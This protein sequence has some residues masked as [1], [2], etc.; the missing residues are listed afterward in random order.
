VLVAAEKIGNAKDPAVLSM[1]VTV[2]VAVQAAAPP[3]V[4]QRQWLLW[5]AAFFTLA[6]LVHNGDH[7]R[8]GADAVTWE[9]FVL[10]T[11]AIPIE[12][13]VV[14]L[15]FGRHR[16][17]PLVA[18]VAGAVL[19]VGYV[20]VHFLPSWSDLSDSFVSARNAS[21]LSWGAASLE[22]AAALI[23][24]FVGLV[25]LTRSGWQVRSPATDADGDARPLGAALLHPV[26]LAMIVG[27]VLVLAA[28]FF[29]LAT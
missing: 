28:S 21:S 15:A 24:T 25:E 29:Q 17:A 11:L 3:R 14:V 4:G 26:A 13:A 12:I 16:L 19:S 1:G 5:A 8:R 20:T 2:D 10:G 6:V 18:A 7:V 27:N 9:V 23:L 22:V